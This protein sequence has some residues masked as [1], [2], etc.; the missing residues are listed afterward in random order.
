MSDLEKI[1]GA[2]KADVSDLAKTHCAEF[3]QAAKTDGELFVD[4]AKD[5]I[6]EWAALLVTGQIKPKELE[7]LVRSK[8]DIAK[9]KVLK[10]KGLAQ[11]KI[12]K[13]IAGIIDSTIKRIIG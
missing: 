6:A 3:A 9:M 10:M 13:F 12:D 4:E 5:D 1:V 11:I 7:L 8:K 2:I